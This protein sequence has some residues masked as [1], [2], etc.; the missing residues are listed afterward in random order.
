MGMKLYDETMRSCQKLL[1]ASSG[2]ELSIEEPQWPDISDSRMILRSDMA[3]ELGGERLPAVGLTLVTASPELVPDDGITLIG[4]DLPQIHENLPYARV[5]LVRVDESTLGEGEA[6]Y[7]VIR[8][9]EYTRYHCYPEGFMMRVSAANRRECVRVGRTAI[10]NGLDFT[11]VGNTMRCAFRKNRHVKA[12]QLFYVTTAEFNYDVL[13][14][15]AK[16]AEEITGTIDHILKNVMTDCASCSLQKVCDEVE[17]LR[18]LHFA[19]EKQT[20][21]DSKILQSRMNK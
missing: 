18:E 1:R 21:T 11:K 20:E 4:S 19:K 6:L 13:K 9:L 10:E 3:Y 12:V 8:D 7:R 5:A 14:E 15:A 17:G 2:K 16:E